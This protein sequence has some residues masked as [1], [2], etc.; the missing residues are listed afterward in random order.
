MPEAL[1]LGAL[2]RAVERRYT[3]ARILDILRQAGWAVVPRRAPPNG[4]TWDLVRTVT[5]NAAYHA[6]DVFE[7]VYS[8]VVDQ[9][10]ADLARHLAMLQRVDLE[11]ER[12]AAAAV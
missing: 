4:D 2:E 6:D 3:A 5:V 1:L 7:R 9:A 8:A 10:E 12:T 11:R